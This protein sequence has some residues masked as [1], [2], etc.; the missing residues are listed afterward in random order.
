MEYLHDEYLKQR[1]SA[2]NVQFHTYDRV[3]ANVCQTMLQ[4]HADEGKRKLAETESTNSTADRQICI[5]QLE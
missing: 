3:H 1:A 4:C 2:A 5:G